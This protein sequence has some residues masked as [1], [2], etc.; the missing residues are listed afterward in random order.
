[1]ADNLLVRWLGG[2]VLMFNSTAPLLNLSRTT[3]THVDM[4][5]ENCSENSNEPQDLQVP[6]EDDQAE[7]GEA[8]P[9][10]VRFDRKNIRSLPACTVILY[11][12]IYQIDF[13]SK[14]RIVMW[15]K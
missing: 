15:G 3:S 2:H 1:M 13:N 12:C 7:G 4:Q 11:S 9:S 14:N 6:E 10:Q 5:D 8:E